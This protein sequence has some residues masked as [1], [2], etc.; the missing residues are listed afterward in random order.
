[1]PL[2][3]V[4]LAER[5]ALPLQAAGG[6]VLDTVRAVLAS[7]GNL[8]ATARALFVH[9]NT[10]RY[11]LKRATELTGWSATDP[12]GGW[13]L[14]IALALAELEGSRSLWS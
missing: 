4:A 1:D 9:P 11:R 5:V 13:T 14:Q 12:R 2:A 7:G 3:R 6:E 8:E 10:V